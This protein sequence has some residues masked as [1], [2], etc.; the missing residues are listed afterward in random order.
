M[1]NYFAL[2]FPTHFYT[3]G[4]PGTI[5]D[6]Y[7]AG[8]PV[9]SAKWE[10]FDDVVDNDITGVGYDFDNKGQFEDVL[11]YASKNFQKLFDMK[12]NCICKANNYIPESTIQ[13]MTRKIL[14]R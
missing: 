9:I 8:V 12:E 6:A 4:I 7:A 1:K 3:E 14:G 5:I 13:I 2:L 11:F 10:S